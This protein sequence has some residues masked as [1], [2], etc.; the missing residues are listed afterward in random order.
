MIIRPSPDQLDYALCAGQGCIQIEKQTKYRTSL[1]CR[2]NAENKKITPKVLVEHV[3]KIE[4]SL[5][6]YFLL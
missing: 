2:I 6:N 3:V 4:W 5:K 1:L